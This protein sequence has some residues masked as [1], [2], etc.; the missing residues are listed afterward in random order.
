MTGSIVE[1]YLDLLPPKFLV[2]KARKEW[3]LEEILGALEENGIRPFDFGESQEHFIIFASLK[4]GFDTE[5]IY[6][7]ENVF[8]KEKEDGKWI[9]T[10]QKSTE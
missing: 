9:N 4:K 10:L 3:G 8:K 1:E 6:I 5:K 7:F 2:F